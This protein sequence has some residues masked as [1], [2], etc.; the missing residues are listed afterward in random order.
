MKRALLI[1]SII[2]AVISLIFAVDM[3]AVK[4][5]WYSA[6]A[7]IDFIGLPVG[8]VYGSYIDEGGL[9]HTEEW[10]F[11]TQLIKGNGTDVN[12]LVNS[13][14]GDKISIL[15]SPEGET[16]CRGHLLLRWM[17]PAMISAAL[18]LIWFILLLI[19][20]IQRRRNAAR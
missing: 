7:T 12:E 2:F 14:Y 8:A 6:E 19:R 9:Q 5:G 18:L 10:L 1:T 20:L 4:G 16:Y 13:F 11:L 15:I 17:V 3:Y